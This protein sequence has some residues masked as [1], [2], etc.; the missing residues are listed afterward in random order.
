MEQK[1]RGILTGFH[2]LLMSMIAHENLYP[3]EHSAVPPGTVT[4]KK[5]ARPLPIYN[6]GY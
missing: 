6:R 5:L 2:F 4:T 3:V 1:E